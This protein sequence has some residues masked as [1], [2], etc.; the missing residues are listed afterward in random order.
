LRF[1]A[2]QGTT[3]HGV[4][5]V[6]QLRNTAFASSPNDRAAA[7]RHTPAATKSPLKK[8]TMANEKA[9]NSSD[10]TSRACQSDQRI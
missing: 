3:S 2:A 5:I 6:H 8:A 1:G 4:S 9:G 7:N 10:A